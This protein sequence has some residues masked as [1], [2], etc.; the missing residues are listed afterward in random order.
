MSKGRFLTST[1]ALAGS[2][3]GAWALTH[4]FLAPAIAA[5]AVGLVL[6]AKYSGGDSTDRQFGDTVR[7]TRVD[8]KA[9]RKKRGRA[10]QISI[11]GIPIPRQAEPQHTL[12]VGSQ[13]TGKSVICTS[14]MDTIRARGQRAVVYDGTGE[15]VAHYYRPD[16][17]IILSPI[18]TR[19][20]VWSPWAEGR[21][22]FT[23]DNLA[24]ALIPDST[25]ENQFWMV[26]ARAIFQA[27]LEAAPDLRTLHEL[28]FGDQE[29][30][31]AALQAAGLAGLAGPENMLASS[32]ATC[33]TYI[34]PLAYLPPP[35]DKPFSIRDWVRD[36]SRDSWLFVPSRESVRIAIRPLM[37]LWFG[38]AIQAVMTLPPDRDRR[39]W[40]ILDELPYL[41]NLPSLDGALSG[42]RKYGLSA[43]LGTQG[44]AQLRKVYG[45]DAATA[46]LSYPATRVTLKVGDSETAQYLSD[47]LGQRHTIRKV[48]SESQNPG[49]GGSSSSE[50]HAIE[51]AV[52]P[53]EIMGLPDMV[54]YLRV[55]GDPVIKKIRL[56]RRD[57]AV[58]AEPY[59]DRPLC[60][61]PP[62]AN[63]AAL[64]R[65]PATP[66]LDVDGPDL[67]DL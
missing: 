18:D 42:G 5:A 30:L 39:L 44:I 6:H 45:R 48:S 2:A 26:A 63:P 17:D 35:G 11:G 51:H 55:S 3:A 57:R 22:S 28:I 41:Q 53:S 4:N 8:D 29:F 15:F 38:I 33:A 16:R 40:L 43:V 36:E 62:A 34:K 25:G 58:L 19:S 20:A 50:Q 66:G 54:G 32:R 21:D 65:A 61:P 67:P 37:S 27:A 12:L 14:I 52:L 64:T 60:T 56:T 9:K 24:T 49:G 47:S 13:G 1:I 10:D 46:I 7:G 59:Q 23:Y 31:L